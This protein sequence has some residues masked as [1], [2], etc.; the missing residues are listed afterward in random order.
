MGSL[1]ISMGYCELLPLWLAGVVLFRDV[2]LIAAGFVIRYISLP[3]PVRLLLFVYRLFHLN[4]YL[5]LIFSVLF[6]VISMPHMLLLNW[7]QH[8]LAKLILV[9]NWPPLALVWV[10]RCGI[11]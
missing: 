6:L 2:F 9:F 1:V 10:H 8:L 3:P 7:S 5:L 11:I 4:D